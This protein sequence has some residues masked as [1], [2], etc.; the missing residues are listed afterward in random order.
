MPEIGLGIGR[1]QGTYQGRIREWLFWS[2]QDG[3]RYQT[4]EEVNAQQQQQ[5][6]QTQQQLQELLARLQ[7]QGIGPN[8]L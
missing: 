1:E 6:E 7:Q 5:L 8:L 2:D 4:P 3:N